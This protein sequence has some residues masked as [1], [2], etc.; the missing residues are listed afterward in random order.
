LVAAALLLT[1]ALGPGIHA[2]AAGALSES[3]PAAGLDRTGP[4]ASPSLPPGAHFHVSPDGREQALCTCRPA[5]EEELRDLSLSPDGWVQEEPRE[6]Y[7]RGTVPLPLVPDWVGTRARAAGGLA[8][9]DA[10]NDGDLDLAVGTYWG[11]MYPPIP[12]Y[13]NFIYLNADG[14]IS[15]PPGWISPDQKH[16]TDLEWARINNDEYPD[17]FVANGGESLQQ[18]QVFYGQDGLL[19]LTAGWLSGDNCWSIDAALC[20]FDRDN[21]LDVALAN[22]GNS[23]QPY[24]PTQLYRNTGN[25]LETTPF[26]SSDQIGITNSADWGDMDGD[27]WPDLAVA[28]WVNWQSGVFR[29]LGATLETFFTWTTGHPERMDKGI[30]WSDVNGDELPDLCFGGN[31]APEWLF[32][33]QGV[34]LGNTPVWASADTYHGC[35]ELAWVDIDGDGDEDLATVHFSTGH[36][37][38]HLNNSGVLSTVADWQYDDA[39]SATAIAFGDVNGDQMPDLAVGVANGPVKVFLNTGNPAGVPEAAADLPRRGMRLLAGPNPFHDRLELRIE[40]GELASLDRLEVAD[41]SGRVVARLGREIRPTGSIRMTPAAGSGTGEESP[42]V[43]ARVRSY[44]WAPGRGPE[45]ASGGGEPA[46]GF[47]SGVYFLRAEGRDG[48]GRPLSATSK[49]VRLPS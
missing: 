19:P 39:T 5:T 14:M 28:G 42:V 31:S 30:G 9:G 6:S 13:Y 24:R 40:S 46:W 10:D 41:A 34:V 26:W 2:A 23:V 7:S 18:S 29:N 1:T 21:D 3:A 12:D 47:P 11:N 49:V 20:D 17:L 38:I 4:A 16:T 48:S 15:E 32:E 45:I 33:N 22:Q 27:G 8:W 44:T 36:V 43:S 25:G 35:Q 37:R